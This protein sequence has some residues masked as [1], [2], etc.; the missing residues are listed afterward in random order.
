VA[1]AALG[2]GEATN[3]GRSDVDL[4]TFSGKCSLS[5]SS[6]YV[7]PVIHAT[8]ISFSK[9]VIVADVENP[10]IFNF[11]RV[12]MSSSELTI[13]YEHASS[14]AEDF[15]AFG[16]PFLQIGNVT[17]PNAA[18][19]EF[20]V[21]AI[22]TERCFSSYEG[23]SVK[24]FSASIRSEGSFLISAS[25]GNLSG[26]LVDPKGDSIFEVRG[27]KSFVPL[28]YFLLSGSRVYSPTPIPLHTSHVLPTDTQLA[29]IIAS[30]HPSTIGTTQIIVIVSSIAGV[31]IITAIVVF[32]VY[33]SRH[34]QKEAMSAPLTRGNE[35][36][37]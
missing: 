26:Y 35:Y 16:Y 33:R 22:D 24:G 28:V 19:W 17:L 30:D 12:I 9:A 34:R 21:S 10:P 7:R 1:G 6:K 14:L 29:T 4:L 15:T 20:C 18:K 11:S 36:F 25:S 32:V 31:I 27:G 8:T 23:K 37:V 5:L 13:F 3:T 2:K